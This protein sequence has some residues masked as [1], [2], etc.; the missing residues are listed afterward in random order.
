MVASAATRHVS[1]HLTA[2]YDRD[3]TQRTL[4]RSRN[5][6]LSSAGC[7]AK[8]MVRRRGSEQY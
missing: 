5:N 2:M 6:L 3:S 4:D 7:A 1:S 8:I